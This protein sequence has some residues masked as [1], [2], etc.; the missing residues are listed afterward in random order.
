MARVANS[1]SISA[2][3]MEILLG[4]ML[5]MLSC[6]NREAYPFVF[7]YDTLILECQKY[8]SLMDV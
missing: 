5:E 8:L 7:I 1:V 6:L 3:D 2:I 4:K